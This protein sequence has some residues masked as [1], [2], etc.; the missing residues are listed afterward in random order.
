M[1]ILIS[2]CSGLVGTALRTSLEADGH[3]VIPL[4]RCEGA[5]RS[6]SW[7]PSGG[8]ID[9]AGVGELDAVVHLAGD[10][11]ADG[12]WNAAKKKRIRDSRVLGTRLLVSAL[13]ALPKPPALFLSASGISIHDPADGLLAQVCREWEAEASRAEL[14]GMRVVI[15][16]LGV[17]LSPEGGALHQMLR[18]FRLGLGGVI[19]S[20]TQVM[21][22][23]S[24]EDVVDMLRFL[25]ERDTLSG[26]F[27][28]VSTHP[29]TNREFTKAFGKA[30]HRPTILP[31]PAFLVKLLFGEMA[32]EAI[33]SSIRVTPDALQ[34][35]GYEMRFPMLEEYLDG[36]RP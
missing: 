6:P 18:P 13:A 15:A 17:V 7:D 27:D 2:G 31:M 29:V 20:G 9:L 4:M 25:L 21:S 32:E 11:I 8:S 35:A 28:L 10:N 12:R 14:A 23:V 3:Q 33:L 22:W 36:I 24:L 26:P 30:L 19:G 34:A 16:R 5:Q 1:R